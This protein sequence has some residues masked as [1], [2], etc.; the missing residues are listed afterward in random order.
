MADILLRDVDNGM[1]ERVK[2]IARE[3]GWP[4]HDVLLHALKQG[5][6]II[7]PEPPKEPGDIARLAGS[8]EDTETRAFDEALRA[9]K[10]LEDDRAY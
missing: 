5:L 6:G 10:Q 9:L 4:I 3:R 7:E 1:V 8:F 2:Q